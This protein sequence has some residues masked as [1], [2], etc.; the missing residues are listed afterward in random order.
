MCRRPVASLARAVLTGRC[1]GIVLA[2]NA[3]LHRK[4]VEVLPKNLKDKVIK[5]VDVEGTEEEGQSQVLD[6]LGSAAPPSQPS[7]I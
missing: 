5:V 6:Q 7:R 4:L 2:G 1:Q 3:G